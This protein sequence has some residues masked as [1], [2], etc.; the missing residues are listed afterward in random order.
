[1]STQMMEIDNETMAIIDLAAIDQLVTHHLDFLG[2][3]P[4]VRGGITF[5]DPERMSSL[6]E[7][8][9]N[10]APQT[11]FRFPLIKLLCPKQVR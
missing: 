10:L 6:H 11:C 7:D 5:I 3:H 8:W 2:I 4:E 1:M 9:K